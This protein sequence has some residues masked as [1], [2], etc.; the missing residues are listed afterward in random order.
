MATLALI[1]GARD[2]GSYSGDEV[3]ADCRC[4]VPDDVPRLGSSVN[5]TIG[6]PSGVSSTT[7]SF[8]I[9]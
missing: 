2:V 4:D 8:K 5:S 7:G 6:V 1:H 9:T 3:V